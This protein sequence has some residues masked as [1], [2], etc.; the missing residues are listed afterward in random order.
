MSIVLYHH[1]FSRAANTVWMLEEVGVEYELKFVDIMAGEQ[2]KETIL[3]LNPMG[4][5]PLLVD[6]DTAITESAAIGLYLADRYAPG[7]L[8]P[9]LDSPARGTYFRWSLFAPSVIEPGS[10]A[11]AG[12]WEVRAMSAGW[13]NYDDILKTMESA[14]EGRDF[15]LGKEFSMA[16][17]IFGGTIA[18]MLDF[19]MLEPRPGFTAYAERVKARPAYARS[20]ARNKAVMDEH[21]LKMPG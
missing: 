15:V 11:K 12:N 19:K 17:L 16:D 6:G 10:M 1:P 2:K 9:T 14:I 13:G 5:L 3:K 8:A 21:G 7:R 20:Q 4:K 18:Y